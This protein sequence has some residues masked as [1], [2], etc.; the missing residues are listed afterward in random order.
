VP[1]GISVA[2]ECLA[3]VATRLF[4]EEAL[5]ELTRELRR[6]GVLSNNGGTGAEPRGPGTAPDREGI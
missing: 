2:R 5:A 4:Y 6:R 3:D 1:S